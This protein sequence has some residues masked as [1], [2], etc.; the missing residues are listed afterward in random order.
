MKSLFPSD[1][2]D[3]DYVPNADDEDINVDNSNN[4]TN[5][6][7][8]SNQDIIV[9]NEQNK[10]LEENQNNENQRQIASNSTSQ[11]ISANNIIF[12]QHV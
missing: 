7:K 1:E 3:K 4:Y 2:E 6:T 11:G 12:N 8:E 5:E 9:T 10:T